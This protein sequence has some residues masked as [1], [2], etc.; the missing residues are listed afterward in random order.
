M[1]GAVAGPALV[2]NDPDPRPKIGALIR[3]R[4]K[5]QQ[6]TLKALGQASGLSVGY[7]SQLERDHATPSLAT[8]VQIAR[9]LDVGVDYFI[10][11]P[12]AKDALTRSNERKTFSVDGSSVIYERLSAEFPGNVLSSFVMTVPPGYVSETVSHEGE[13]LLF[14]LEGEITQTLDGEV[15]VMREGDSL[16]FRGNKPH[17]WSNHTDKPARLLWSGTLTLFRSLDAAKVLP[18][19]HNKPGGKPAKTSAKSKTTSKEKTS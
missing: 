18:D 3:A 14:V 10:A 19:A 13:E 4:R 15:M 2:K 16:H 6:M 1:E 11:A 12:S 17:A 9:T 8:L 5:Q 7:L